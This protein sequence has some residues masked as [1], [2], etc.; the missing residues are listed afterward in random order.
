MDHFEDIVGFRYLRAMHLNDSKAPFKSNKDLH[1]N[2]GTGATQTSYGWTPTD[3][4][5]APFSTK[6]M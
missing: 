3:G 1:A 5:P 2:I 6:S 4:T